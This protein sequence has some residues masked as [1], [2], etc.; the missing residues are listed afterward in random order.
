[1]HRFTRRGIVLLATLAASD[2]DPAITVESLLSFHEALKAAGNASEFYV[3]KGGKHGLCNGRNP[4][5]RFFYWSL[6]LEDRFL[7]NYGLL[8]GTSKVTRP[9]GVAPLGKEDYDAYK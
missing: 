9:K 6:E 5:N 7:V 3:G 1:M 2:Q 8:G 4:Q